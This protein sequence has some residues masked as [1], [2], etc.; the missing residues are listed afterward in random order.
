MRDSM[1]D[2]PYSEIAEKIIEF[3]NTAGI[4][5]SGESDLDQ[6]QLLEGDN[7]DSLGI[8]QLMVFL[9]QTFEI[10]IEDEDFQPENFETVG[11]LKAFVSRKMSE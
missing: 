9:G 4:D 8:V 3:F 11:T 2:I 7:L 6:F 5:V 10:E 1:T